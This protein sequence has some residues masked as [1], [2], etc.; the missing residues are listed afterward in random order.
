MPGSDNALSNRNRMS[1][2][3]PQFF[4]KFL[5]WRIAGCFVVLGGWPVQQCAIFRDHPIEN[6]DLWENLQQVRQF[7]PGCQYQFPSGNLYTLQRFDGTG[8]D[9]TIPSDRAVVVAC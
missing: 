9:A 2:P 5:W 6:S 1:T 8:R 7:T 3:C 4:D